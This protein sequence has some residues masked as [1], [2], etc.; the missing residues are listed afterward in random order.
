[1]TE[2]L[3]SKV[4][5]NEY[6][7]VSPKELSPLVLAYIG[8]AVYE[9]LA[10]TRV[11][12]LGNAPVNKMNSKARKI[13]NAKSQCEAYFK[14]ADMLTDEECGKLLKAVLK[15]DKYDE[16]TY[17]EDRSLMLCYD[18]IIDCLDKNHK[19]YQ[20]TCQ[21]RVEAAKKRW[22]DVK[23]QKAAYSS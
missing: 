5:N 11:V 18:R 2:E 14:M 19:K 23:K 1:M 13:V 3:F 7:G 9:I 12:S 17:F 10:R 4:L 6:S 20:E 21:K 22:E 8:D 15:Y 16:E